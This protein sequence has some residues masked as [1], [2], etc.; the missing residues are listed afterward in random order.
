MGYQI[1]LKEGFMSTP[2]K[3]TKDKS[4]KDKKPADSTS[5]F[6]EKIGGAIGW[7]WGN[8]KDSDS[9]SDSSSWGW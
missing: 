2:K 8:S 6:A 3:D 5:R 7:D 4:K 1:I 9:K